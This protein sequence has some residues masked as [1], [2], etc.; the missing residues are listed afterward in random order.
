MMYSLPV[1]CIIPYRLL[2][3][4]DATTRPICIFKLSRFYSSLEGIGINPRHK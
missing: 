1:L 2:A 4:V 3:E